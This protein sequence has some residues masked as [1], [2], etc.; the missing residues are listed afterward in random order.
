MTKLTDLEAKMLQNIER[1]AEGP[2]GFV[3]IAEFRARQRELLLAEREKLAQVARLA[4]MN[5]ED[6]ELA[7][8]KYNLG[9][10][11]EVNSDCSKT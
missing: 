11:F 7:I 1:M 2:S 3:S 4:C 8:R 10:L 5:R 9:N 6:P